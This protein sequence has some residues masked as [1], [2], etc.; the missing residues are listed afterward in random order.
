MSK[1]TAAFAKHPKAFVPFITSG[2]PDLETTKKLIVAMAEAG[3]TVVELG[4]PFSDPVA[5]GEVIQRANIRALKEGCTTDKI[6]AMIK[7]AR[8]ETDVPLVFL[9]YINPIFTYG[10]DKFYAKCAEVGVDG[11]II[12][13]IPFEE[14]SE[15]LGACQK[16]GVDLISLIAPTSKDRIQM[17]AKEAMGYI[18]LVSSLGVTGVRREI[19]TDI[20]AIVKEIRKVSAKPVAVGF[21]IATPEQAARMASLS[22]G[23]IVGSAIV[24]IIEQH[25]KDA[26][27]PVR[28]FVAAMVQAVAGK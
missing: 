18:Y 14:K 17:I 3:A 4:I 23:A 22:D 25:G 8:R 2:D 16:Y 15:V 9:T 11:T 21:G 10:T 20:G 13:D 24:I 12:P 27:A 5:E 1:I 6:F 28:R 26:V 7:E 19:T